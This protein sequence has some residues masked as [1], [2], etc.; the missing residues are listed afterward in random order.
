MRKNHNA[1]PVGVI[2]VY[3]QM[4]FLTCPP[5]FSSHRMF[6]SERLGLALEIDAPRLATHSPAQRVD[7][8]IFCF[9]PQAV[10]EIQRPAL[11]RQNRKLLMGKR[12]FP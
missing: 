2:G 12:R 1:K 4:H 9:Q 10:K 7:V 8:R 3:V 11:R 6:F 5:L